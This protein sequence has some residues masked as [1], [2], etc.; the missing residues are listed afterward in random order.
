LVNVVIPR[1]NPNGEP[2]AGVGKVFL[3]YADTESSTKARAGLNGRKFGGNQVVA[4]FYPE[5]KF[6]E[7]VYDG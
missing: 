3:E 1:P 2:V 6:N 5:D 4:S 7:G